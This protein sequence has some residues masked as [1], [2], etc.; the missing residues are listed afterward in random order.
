[1]FSIFPRKL[2]TVFAKQVGMKNQ[3]IFLSA[4]FVVALQGAAN[5]E[6]MPESQLTGPAEET[7]SV[8]RS[9]RSENSSLDAK[10][11][12]RRVARERIL[13]RLRES[14]SR[15]KASV[16]DE[17]S[18][19]GGESSRKNAESRKRETF[20]RAFDGRHQMP[21]DRRMKERDHGMPP[22]EFGEPKF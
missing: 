8:E 9:S 11:A 18:K 1:M 10:R 16:R 22:P 6:T 4:L 13:S 20:P 19:K 21:D 12:E 2:G 14:S 17:L 5:A 7:V 3:K 15:E